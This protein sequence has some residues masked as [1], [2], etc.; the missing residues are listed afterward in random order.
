MKEY[1][2][3]APA[4]TEYEPD[5]P[6]VTEYEPDAPAVTEY[7]PDA[8]AVTEYE[9]D[10]DESDEYETPLVDPTHIDLTLSMQIPELLNDSVARVFCPCCNNEMDTNHICE[11]AYVILVCLFL[12]KNLDCTCMHHVAQDGHRD[13]QRILMD[14]NIDSHACSVN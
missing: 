4:V 11:A 3:D 6:V 9:P 8:P 10:S 14:A 12:S 2:S 5:A 7:E 13:H 1:E